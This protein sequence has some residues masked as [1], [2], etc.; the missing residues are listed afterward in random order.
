VL[1]QGRHPLVCMAGRRET[2]EL[3]IGSLD[4]NLQDLSSLLIYLEY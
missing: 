2:G 4:D 1:Q 3:R